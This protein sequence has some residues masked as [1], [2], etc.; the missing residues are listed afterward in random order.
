MTEVIIPA[1]VQA[2]LRIEG[3]GVGE[4]EPKKIR[5]T[6]TREDRKTY[7]FSYNT[8]SDCPNPLRMYTAP[9][10]I[11]EGINNF[12][13]EIW[14]YETRIGLEG[15][16]ETVYQTVHTKR[17]T[18]CNRLAVRGTRLKKRV[19]NL[20]IVSDVSLKRISFV[21]L[22]FPNWKLDINSDESLYDK[23]RWFKKKVADFR[24]IA[25]AGLDRVV[26]GWDSYEWTQPD[27]GEYNLHHH[28]L[29]VMDYWE[30]KDLQK[31]WEKHMDIEM[32]IVHIKRM[33]D[34]YYSKKL[35]KRIKPTTK[36]DCIFYMTKYAAK[37]N[38]KG[39]RLSESFGQCRGKEFA[40][41]EQ[42]Y[43]QLLAMKS[44]IVVNAQD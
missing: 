22:T 36:A 31:A 10:R 14:H 15:Y 27:H 20:E 6:Y 12:G 35:K 23:I 39:I 21:T 25:H 19:R 2:S 34:W 4:S 26:G 42:R 16:S 18:E 7:G 33:G 11:I 30:Q 44:D 43:V 28:G 37:E 32:A 3:L 5:Y 1:W 38:V 29:W 13:Q 41:V 40:S 17:C 8:C 9:K 24:E